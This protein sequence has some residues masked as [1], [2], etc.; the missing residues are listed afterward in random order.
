MRFQLNYKFRFI[1][2]I[3]AALASTLAC[4][5]DASARNLYVSPDGNDGDG[6][7][8]KKA[9]KSFQ[10]INWSSVVPGD[11]IIV[12]GGASGVTY[13]GPF[14]VPTNFL[15]IRQSPAAN[16]NGVVTIAAASG[17]PVQTGVTITGSNVQLIANARSGIKITNFSGENVKVQT[18]N[19]TFRN[20]EFGTV[21]GF[22]PYGGGRVGAVVFGG[23]DNN[24][25]NCRFTNVKAGAV[26]R[27]VAGQPNATTFRGCIFEGGYGWWGEWGVGILGARP[28]GTA[29]QSLIR[30]SKCVFGPVYNKGIDIVQGQAT[31]VDCLF[32]GANHANV[33][34]EPTDTASKV[35]VNL[36]RCTLY[37]PNLV[38]NFSQHAMYDR[39]F[40]TNG[41][42]TVK[43][44]DC[45]IYGGAINVPV[46]QS[47]DNGGNVQY[48]VT[49]NTTTL[50]S[51]L[52]NPQYVQES[53]LW[54]PVNK[55]TYRPRAWTVQTYELA[56]GSPATEKGCSITNVGAIVPPYGPNSGLPPM[57]GP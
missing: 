51:S 13:T 17:T 52:V 16:H 39:Q 26:E 24:F 2:G 23:Y 12:D 28:N 53:T 50:A 27:P 9:W 6:T 45:I 15:T 25:V 5:A 44:K 40:S 38:S 31:I 20:I 41:V 55:D 29:Y 35:K 14:T 34:V 37:E 32:L 11:Q 10:S 54:A 46:T 7:N 30:A 33:S 36:T 1:A 42:G 3:I 43:V 48:H 19:N 49:G 18:N 56:S 57:G 4:G 47:L 21:Y 22:P 8:W